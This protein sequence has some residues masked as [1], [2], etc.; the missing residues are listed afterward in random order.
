MAQ[1]KWWI[2]CAL[3]LACLAHLGSSRRHR[4]HR[5]HGSQP[6]IFNELCAMKADPGS[7][8]AIKDRFFYNVS[9]TRCEQFEY[10]GCGGNTNN[11]VTLQECE[12]TCV[13]SDEKNPCH[14]EEAPGPCRGL[15]SRYMFDSKIRQCRRFYYGGC[16][17]NANNFRS[18]AECQAKCQN[19][20]P[21]DVG[22]VVEPPNIPM[23]LEEKKE[24]SSAAPQVST[25]APRRFH[26]VQ[27]AVA[28]ENLA[29]AN[30]PL[31]QLNNSLGDNNSLT[32]ADVCLSPV[33]P[34]D[35][36]CDG[37]VRRYAYV[38]SAKRCLSF[39]Y[40]GC[41]GN[42]NN[43]RFRKHCVH[44]CVLPRK[45][46]HLSK[47]MIRIRKKNVNSIVNPDA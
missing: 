40:T 19:P 45:G 23:K 12:E 7:C 1:T 15:L 24:T 20:G 14:L 8:R 16:F 37:Q 22:G 17:G 18:M 9:T 41:G 36:D 30:E 3:S 29:A 42:E 10:G 47:S 38:E 6:I 34:G 25:R 28:S 46:F 31:V 26:F 35:S 11:F 33:D 39:A 44:K 21:R 2:F 43:F 32:P 4:R 13:V 5:D 27:P